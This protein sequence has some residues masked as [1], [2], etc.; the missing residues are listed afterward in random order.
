MPKSPTARC[1]CGGVK[2]DGRCDRCGR[3]KHTRDTRP[4]RHMYQQQAWRKLSKRHR[5][6]NPLCVLCEARGLTTPAELVDHVTPHDGDM[7]L[8]LDGANIQSLCGTCHS[9]DKARIEAAHA[10]EQV[11]GV[12][13]RYMEGER[14][15]ER[16]QTL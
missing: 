11:S 3:T 4:H 7:T 9:R 12:W 13:R 10:P 2:R 1:K 5:Q 15:S 14:G 6:A 16:T 8:F